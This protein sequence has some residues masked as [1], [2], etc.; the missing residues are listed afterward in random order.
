[1]E[2][3]Y[4]TRCIRVFKAS[5]KYNYGPKPARRKRLWIEVHLLWNKYKH[6]G[7]LIQLFPTP[8]TNTKSK[9]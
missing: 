5:S 1:M 3:N 9:V 2:T 8:I 7:K 4:S 6:H